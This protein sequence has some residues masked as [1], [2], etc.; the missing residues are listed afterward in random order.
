MSDSDTYE[1][2]AVKYGT[3]QQRWRKD[4][5]I[6][7]D[8]H[9]AAMP[10]DYFVWAITNKERTIVVDTGFDKEEGRRRGRTVT[11]LPREGLAMLDIDAAKVQDVVVTHLHYDHAGTLDD[12]P[13]ARFHIQDRELNYTTGRHMCAEP[14]RHAYTVDH[15]CTLVRR[16]FDGRVAFHDGD[17][18]IAPG[19]SVHLIGG[20]TMGIQ[21]VRV[22]TKRG[23]LVLASDACHFYENME[24]AM[25]FPIVYHVGEMVEGWAKL[26][27][28][29][30]SPQHV[31]PGHDPLVLQQ[32]PAPKKELEGVVVR[33]DVAPKG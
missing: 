28:L 32:Y 30:E 13:A 25:P 9:D 8:D 19:V 33:L 31:V 24:R 3:M 26:K 12:F 15:V 23:W 4:S 20:H 21:S 5:F 6:M 7:A 1:V 18:E 11:R 17:E 10:I 2:Y 16:V 27:R 22:K 29:A 14:F